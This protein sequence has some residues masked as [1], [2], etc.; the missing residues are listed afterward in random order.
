MLHDI[1][2]Y[3]ERC[4]ETISNVCENTRDTTG[5]SLMLCQLNAHLI[6][7]N[8]E[9]FSLFISVTIYFRHLASNGLQIPLSLFYLYSSR[10][11]NNS[12]VCVFPYLPILPLKW[13]SFFND[14]LIEPTF[15]FSS[16]KFFSGCN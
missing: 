12:S 3:I 11:H 13:T 9:L 7:S 14:P 4:N 1:C 2:Y 5:N 6:Y 16:T 10:L 8:I 15:L